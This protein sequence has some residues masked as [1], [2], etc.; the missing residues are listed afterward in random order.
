MFNTNVLGKCA[1]TTCSFIA[2]L[3]IA[4][5]ATMTMI[6]DA[7]AGGLE[8]KT[9]RDPISNRSLERGLV[10]GK[11]WF[12][13]STGASYKMS[14]AYWDSTGVK[15]DW[16]STSWLYTTEYMDLKYGITRNVEFSWKVKTH[17]VGLTNT[18]LGTDFHQF[19]MGDPEVGVK[20]QL[21]RSNAPLQSVIAYGSYKASVANEMPGNYVGGPNTF[22]NFIL[23]TGTPDLSIGLAGKAQFG[24]MALTVDLS[25]K[26]RFSGL[27]SYAIETD[28]N[29]FQMR[30]KPGNVEKLDV[31]GETQLG[32]V[33]LQVGGVYQQRGFF[34]IGS[35]SKGFF[36]NKNLQ[37][38]TD[39]NGWSLDAKVGATINVFNQMDIK[40]GALLPIRG[41]DLLFFPL[42][43]VNPTYGAVY[44]GE[45]VYRF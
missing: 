42:E 40:A 11:G 2:V 20:Y 30:V 3:S 13:I 15:Q 36:P 45:L 37:T 44:N 27:T 7:Q 21:Y 1:S 24:P 33:N 9:M 29:Q 12:Q 43:E 31:T 16:D 39:S 17:Y 10:L 35:T 6:S 8:G 19:G 4:N 18:H 14:S 38:I 34:E 32:F 28:M 22:S 23:T 5:I 26:Q 41:E 25:H